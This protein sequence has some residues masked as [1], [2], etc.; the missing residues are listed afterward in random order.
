MQIYKCKLTKMDYRNNQTKLKLI[1]ALYDSIF[2]VIVLKQEV[3]HINKFVLVLV[4]N[5][6]A[7]EATLPPTNH[8][9]IIFTKIYYLTSFA[10]CKLP[11]IGPPFTTKHYRF[12]KWRMPRQ[13]PMTWKNWGHLIRYKCEG[14][15]SIATIQK[16]C[17]KLQI[18]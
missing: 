13:I 15:V 2:A 10:Y 5:I 7:Q 6:L 11:N 14:G 1:Q 8:S 17:Q 4:Y 9:R 18:W 16:S 3:Q 12:I